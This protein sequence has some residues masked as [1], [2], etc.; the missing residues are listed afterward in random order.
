MIDLHTRRKKVEEN[1]E[2]SPNSH[3]TN[4]VEEE[5]TGPVSNVKTESMSNQHE[6]EENSRQSRQKKKE[7]NDKPM[8]FRK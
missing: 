2:K 3:R 1:S 7:T 4:A 8:I 5:V 6:N